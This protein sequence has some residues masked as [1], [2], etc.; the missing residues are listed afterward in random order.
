M[1][2]GQT[3]LYTG[4][5]GGGV[6]ALFTVDRIVAQIRDGLN[7]R[8]HADIRSFTDSG[9]VSARDPY[10]PREC[11]DT[12]DAT[13][14]N[15]AGGVENGVKAWIPEYPQYCI[16]NSLTWECFFGNYSFSYIET[17]S[18]VFNYQ[19]DYAQLDTDGLMSFHGS[20]NDLEGVQW[21]QEQAE[22]YVDT[23]IIANGK[24]NFFFLPGCWDH[25]IMDKDVLQDVYIG[26]HNLVDAMREWYKGG[27]QMIRLYD[28]D[29]VMN[30][31]PTCLNIR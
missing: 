18:F 25:E 2:E 30:S 23:E 20:Y 7:D 8:L 3:I 10:L 21:A 26:E 16:D 28:D 15:I 4:K 29:W 17:P 13:T 22:Y 12:V 19:Y 24:S 31:N 6:S 11:E 27:L 14:C 9:Y 5:G 1:D